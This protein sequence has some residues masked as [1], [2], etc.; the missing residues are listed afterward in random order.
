MKKQFYLLATGLFTVCIV[1]AQIKKG[2]ILLGG[3]LNFSKQDTKPM[4]SNSTSITV[5]PSFGIATKDNQVIGFN[6]SYG[7][8]KAENYSYPTQTSDIYGAGVF[9]RRYKLLGSGFSLFAEGNF[10][11]Y[12]SHQ[13]NIYY[14]GTGVPTDTKGYSFYLG[15]YPGIAYAISRHVQLETGFQNLAYASYGHTKTTITGATN[16]VKTDNFLLGTA[17]NNNLGGFTVGLK[18]LL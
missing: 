1:N 13:K 4:S 7:H 18:W 6:L 9:L 11:G 3:N 10:M 15:F 8:T 14:T 5:A 2:D 16:D 12:Y 17:L